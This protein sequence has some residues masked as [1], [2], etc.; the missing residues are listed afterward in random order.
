M[1]GTR[2]SQNFHIYL[3]LGQS[4]MEGAGVIEQVDKLNSKIPRNRRHL[5][6]FP[7]EFYKSSAII[8]ALWML[9]IA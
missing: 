2:A 6:E 9:S 1:L 5:G 4:N 3:C 7:S 8:I